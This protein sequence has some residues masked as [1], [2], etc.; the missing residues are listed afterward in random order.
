[1]KDLKQEVRNI[2]FGFKGPFTV[3]Q[4]LDKCLQKGINNVYLIFGAIEQIRNEKYIEDTTL[5]GKQAFIT[6]FAKKLQ[7]M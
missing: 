4:L 2:I 3:Q 1:M 5:N 6:F 7:G